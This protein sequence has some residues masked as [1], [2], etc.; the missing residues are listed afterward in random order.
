MERGKT[1]REAPR[2][3]PRGAG[4]GG[5][6]VEREP[7]PIVLDAASPGGLRL[8]TGGDVD[9][10]VKDVV[11]AVFQKNPTQVEQVKAGKDKVKGF[12]VGQALKE[13]KGAADPKKVQAIVDEELAR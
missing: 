11:R 5:P 9:D 10:K 6:P 2:L 4:L 13:L 3:L 8:A 7:L 12:L 1:R